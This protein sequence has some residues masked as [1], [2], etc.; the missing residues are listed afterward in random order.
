MTN[1]AKTPPYHLER[2]GSLMDMSGRQ[3]FRAVDPDFGCEVAVHQVPG[4]G[5]ILFIDGEVQISQRDFEVYHQAMLAFVPKGQHIL[6]IGDGDGGFTNRP[7]YRIT[8][9]E[10]STTVRD[11]ASYA[12]G[13]CW[14]S[15]PGYDLHSCTLNEYLQQSDGRFDAVFLAITDEFNNDPENF[16]DV[17]SVWDRIRSGGVLVA[18]V[19][20]LKDPNFNSYLANYARFE[21]ELAQ[22]ISNVQQSRPFIPCFHS[23]H[24]FYAYTKA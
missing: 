22:G 14:D 17:I 15:R 8:Q 10:M 7:D 5:N 11:A 2:H 3:I 13:V 4:H 6:V 24:V 16:K 21:H 12:F 9:V 18:Q 20:C 19:G 1:L 23:E